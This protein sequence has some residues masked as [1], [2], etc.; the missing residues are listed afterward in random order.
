MQKSVICFFFILVFLLCDGL[1]CSSAH[2]QTPQWRPAEGISGRYITAMDFFKG[3]P[4]TVVALGDVVY[5]S[6]DRGETWDT[7]SIQIHQ[8]LLSAIRVHP[9]DSRRMYA[10][11]R[12]PAVGAN[13]V[14]IS[15]DGGFSWMLKLIGTD[16]YAPVIEI[17]HQHPST[18]Y[19]GEGMGFVKRST[20]W[21]ENWEYVDFFATYGLRS[22][23]ISPTNDSILYKAG[24]LAV[25]KSTDWGVTWNLIR[26]PDPIGNYTGVAVHPGDPDVVY[27]GVE[28]SSGLAGGLFRSTDGG[29]SWQERS[30]GLEGKGVATFLLNPKNPEELYVGSS[31]VGTHDLVYHSIDGGSRWKSISSGL[32]ASGYVV[33]MVLDTVTGRLLA[34]V[35]QLGIYI[36]D[37]VSS[38]PRNAEPESCILQNVPNPFNSHTRVSW[39]LKTSDHVRLEICN[40]LGEVVT[41]LEDGYFSP[42]TYTSIWNASGLPSGVYFCRFRTTSVKAVLKMAL[43]K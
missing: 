38:A 12:G 5:E 4:D 7:L 13:A 17:S 15:T 2:C 32:P 31:A 30:N 43:I 3:N 42:G 11:H 24:F 1:G 27:V 9:L 35:S 39:N 6:T 8:G 18:V 29:T 28:N 10:S 25:Y 19:A 23:A 33:A 14:S 41:V 37:P 40:L 20:D 36:Y 26:G 16:W 22:L 21:G 34:S